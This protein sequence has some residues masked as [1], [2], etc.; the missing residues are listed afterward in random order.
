M[1]CREEAPN[2]AQ[3]IML[4]NATRGR[5][6]TRWS[7]LAW[8]VG[9]NLVACHSACCRNRFANRFPTSRSEAQ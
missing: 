8:S 7:V 1:R 5:R 9:A 3:H 4:S 6:D 2:K